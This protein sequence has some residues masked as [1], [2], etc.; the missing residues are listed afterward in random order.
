MMPF[1]RPPFV[2]LLGAV[3]YAIVKDYPARGEYAGEA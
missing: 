1:A 3:D 2:D